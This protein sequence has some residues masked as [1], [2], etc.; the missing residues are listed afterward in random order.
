MAHFTIIMQEPLIYQFNNKR[1]WRFHY[2]YIFHSVYLWQL[3][4]T[5]HY[6]SFVRALKRV[7]VVIMIQVIICFTT[8]TQL[9]NSLDFICSPVL[10][11]RFNIFVHGFMHFPVFASCTGKRLFVS[12]NISTYLY[13]FLL[14]KSNTIFVCRCALKN[15]FT[16]LKY[17]KFRL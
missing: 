3:L 5:T 4:Q 1:A 16:G 7:N 11:F 6:Y 13:A 12:I 9:I 15:R 8:L 10:L 2:G 17:Y 14:Q